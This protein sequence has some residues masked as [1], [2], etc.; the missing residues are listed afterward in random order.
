MRVPFPLLERIINYPD[1]KEIYY[2]TY[3]GNIVKATK[4]IHS[5]GSSYDFE[6]L[7]EPTKEYILCYNHLDYK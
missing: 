2:E 3:G 5:L 1:D 7:D 6:I 4:I